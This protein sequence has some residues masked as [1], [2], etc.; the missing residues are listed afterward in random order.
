MRAGTHQDR[1]LQNKVPGCP[2]VMQW[3][4]PSSASRCATLRL[5]FRHRE[6]PLVAISRHSDGH[7]GTSALPPIADIGEGIA[8]C[9]LMTQSGHSLSS[10]SAPRP[11]HILLGLAVTQL[12]RVSTYCPLRYRRPGH[13]HRLGHR[14]S[15]SL[16]PDC[17][18]LPHRSD[19]P[20]LLF[21]H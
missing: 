5:L 18:N 8:E 11:F 14:R 21:R 19:R 17:C 20:H 10:R 2:F 7:A 16:V 6:C 1:W 12:K 3:T 4:A 15:P 9:P 13:R